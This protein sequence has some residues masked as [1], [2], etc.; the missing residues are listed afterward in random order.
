M[1]RNSY[2]S[3]NLNARHNAVQSAV[4]TKNERRNLSWKKK[5]HNI[6]QQPRN[7]KHHN[8]KQPPLTK[9]LIMS[10]QTGVPNLSMSPVPNL[11]VSVSVKHGFHNVNVKLSD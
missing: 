3:N 2:Q 8:I 5:H 1:Q 4:C 9:H 7:Q 6:K 11:S 10:V